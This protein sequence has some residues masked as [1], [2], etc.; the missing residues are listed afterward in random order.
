MTH[1]YALNEMSRHVEDICTYLNIPAFLA[2]L[3][4][5]FSSHFFGDWHLLEIW[6]YSTCLDLLLGSW[7]AK[8]RKKFS[9]RRFRSWSC[10]I[11]VHGI[12]IL[13]VGVLAYVSSVALG[14]NVWILNI[15]L[16]IMIFKELASL[17]RNMEKLGWP[18][19]ELLV[20]MVD[21]LEKNASKRAKKLVKNLKGDDDV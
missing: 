19:P 14:Y 21:A 15:Y 16:A 8:K 7:A 1:N 17:V 10:K 3:P 9:V 6:F 11:L 13:I 5:A 12:S 2:S 18:V 4:V 20:H